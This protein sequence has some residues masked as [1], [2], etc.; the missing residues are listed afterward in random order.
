MYDRANR[1]A[2]WKV[3]RMYEVGGNKVELR[4]C[5]LIYSFHVNGAQLDRVGYGFRLCILGDL[6]GWIGDRTKVI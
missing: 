2:L 1:E 5:M 4:V 6:N 3:L